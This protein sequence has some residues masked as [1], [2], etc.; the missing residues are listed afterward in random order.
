MTQTST[1]TNAHN[2]TYESVFQGD[3]VTQI[4]RKAGK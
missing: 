2:V 3:I 1:A 4:K